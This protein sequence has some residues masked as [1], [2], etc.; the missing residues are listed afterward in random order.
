MKTGGGCC[1]VCTTSIMAGLLFPSPP[2]PDNIE[3]IHRLHLNNW[4]LVVVSGGTPRCPALFSALCFASARQ[5]EFP[6]SLWGQSVVFKK[7]LRFYT[8]DAHTLLYVMMTRNNMSGVY[9]MRRFVH[10]SFLC[11]TVVMTTP[12]KCTGE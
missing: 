10:R 9:K 3:A 7:M 6:A 5:R 1:P 12:D 4:M 8:R 2:P 11:F